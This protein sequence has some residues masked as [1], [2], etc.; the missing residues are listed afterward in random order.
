MKLIQ[1]T[2]THLT[3][4][5]QTIAGRDPNANFER[6]LT[7]ALG[8]HPDAE[9]VVITGDLSDWGDRADYERLRASIGELPVPV[10]LAIGNHDDRATFLSVFPELADIN[11]HVQ[12]RFDLS[13]GTGVLI[14]TWEPQTHAG[15]Y[16]ATR[17]AWLD[18]ALSQAKGP[19]YL[20]MHHNPIPTHVGPTDQIMLLDAEAFGSVIAAHRERIAHIFFGHCHQP[21]SGSFH[22]V[23]VS[24]PRGTNHAG[25]ADF[26]ATELLAGSDL[27]EAYAVIIAEGPSVTVHM[28]EFGYRG[29]FRIEGS[30]DYADW[31]RETMVR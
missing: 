5:G 28:V 22:G 21:L 1:L 13:T 31:H 30:P 18:T 29:P 25:W 6:A 16:C 23:P 10:H 24:A 7:H 17:R 8:Q 19:V 27:P 14:D 20:F 12:K 2:D 4:P 15:T 26:E 3:T 9:A 11:G